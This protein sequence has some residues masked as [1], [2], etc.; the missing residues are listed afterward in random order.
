MNKKTHD[1]NKKVAFQNSLIPAFAM[2]NKNDK[3]VLSYCVAQINTVRDINVGEITFEIKDFASVF[4]LSLVDVYQN[5]R[6]SIDR[7]NSFSFQRYEN[8]IHSTDV[9]VI[10]SEYVEYSGIVTIQ[11]NPRLTPL[12]VDLKEKGYIQ[13]SLESAK[14]FTNYGWS[15]YVVLKQWL[16]AGQRSFSIDELKEQLGLKGK[17]PEW[18]LFN[19]KVITPA[20]KNINDVSDIVIGEGKTGRQDREIFFTTMKIGRKI[21]GLHFVI[22]KKTPS[23]TPTGEPVDIEQNSVQQQLNAI[24]IP[25]GV[26]PKTIDALLGKARHYGKEYELLK[27]ATELQKTH[28]KKTKAITGS[29]NEFAKSW[30]QLDLPYEH[31]EHGTPET[32]LPA[33]KQGEYLQKA[34]D[35]YKRKG[36]QCRRKTNFPNVCLMCEKMNIRGGKG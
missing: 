18:D 2:R 1:S 29:L 33:N 10:W 24:L 22:C 19:R 8:G 17:Y 36:N 32:I 27:R 35:C 23:P 3:R 9:W 14:D 7:L 34:L 31:K 12:L 16:K 6:D 15:L 5:L 4:N 20:I 30:P 26:H 11:L 28:G 13:F 21:N 25:C